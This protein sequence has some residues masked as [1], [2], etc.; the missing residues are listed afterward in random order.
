MKNLMKDYPNVTKVMNNAWIERFEKSENTEKVELLFDYLEERFLEESKKLIPLSEELII[1][2]FMYSKNWKN[3]F[4]VNIELLQYNAGWEVYEGY[5][6]YPVAIEVEIE[7]W[8]KN[9][10]ED[11]IQKRLEDFLKRLPENLDQALI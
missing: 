2:V 1:N 11:N 7:D 4:Q 3:F 5:D 9:N 6:K 8:Y 10:E